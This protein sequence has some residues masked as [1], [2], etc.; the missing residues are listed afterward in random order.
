MWTV[1][2]RVSPR[3]RS[4]AADIW[5]RGQGGRKSGDGVG[6]RGGGSVGSPP[7][8]AWGCQMRA[9]VRASS[10]PAAPTLRVAA[11][12]SWVR[13]HGAYSPPSVGKGMASRCRVCG[14]SRSEDLNE[15]LPHTRGRQGLTGEGWMGHLGLLA[16]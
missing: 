10:R 13:T 6:G 1:G 5:G 9:A 2:K 12:H 3:G 16:L 14:F 7:S 4:K 15:S 8:V 11:F